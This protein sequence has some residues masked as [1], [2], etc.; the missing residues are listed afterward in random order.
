VAARAG[1]GPYPIDAHVHDTAMDTTAG[2][3][4]VPAKNMHF[5][6]IDGGNG[7][8][9]SAAA[10]VSAMPTMRKYRNLVGGR[11]CDPVSGD[12]FESVNPATGEA[13]AM[14]PKG[15]VADAE[16]QT[17]QSPQR[18]GVAV[19]AGDHQAGLHEAGLG[20]DHVDDAV[21]RIV[22]VQVGDAP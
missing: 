8:R 13:W 21:P 3:S 19:G 7:P 4:S 10:P 2:R 14:I 16:R 11:W 15:G 9:A 17:A 1:K 22:E 12:W 18:R 6:E 20:A 5:T